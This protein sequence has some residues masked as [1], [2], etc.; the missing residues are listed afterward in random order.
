MHAIWQLTRLK[1]KIYQWVLIKYIT[2]KLNDRVLEIKK[3]KDTLK[4]VL[5]KIYLIDAFKSQYLTLALQIVIN[6]I[7]MKNRGDVNRYSN[8]R[9]IIL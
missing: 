5:I 9:K 2:T 4:W 7:K 8:S 1:L 6:S 3:Y